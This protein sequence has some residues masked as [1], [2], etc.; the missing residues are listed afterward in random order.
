MTLYLKKI[1]P[2]VRPL[3][4]FIFVSVFSWHKSQSPFKI[5]FFSIKHNV[6]L[7]KCI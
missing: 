4:S 7:L 6:L 5:I 2:T 3:R 1:K